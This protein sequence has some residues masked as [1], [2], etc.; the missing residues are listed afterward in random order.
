MNWR[1]TID[2]AILQAF[3]VIAIINN[4][5]IFQRFAFVPK[6]SR[7]RGVVRNVVIHVE[8]AE[9]ALSQLSVSETFYPRTATRHLP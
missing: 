6:Q 8:L 2:C 4:L 5:S 3:E 1:S 9:R 7:Q